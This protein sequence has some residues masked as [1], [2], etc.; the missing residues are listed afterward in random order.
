M[1]ADALCTCGARLHGHY[2]EFGV[3]RGGCSKMVLATAGLEPTRRLHLFDTFEGIPDAS[4][5]ER[6]REAGSPAA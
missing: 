2:A 5:A 6:E 3:Y 1:A 4:L